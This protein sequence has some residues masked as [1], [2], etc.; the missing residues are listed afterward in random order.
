ME[1]TYASGRLGLRLFHL[2]LLGALLS[3]GCGQRETY[4]VRGTVLYEGKPAVGA[5]VFLH[6][7]GASEPMRSRPSGRVGK[8]GSF[9]IT[10]PNLGDGAKPGD[11]LVT[12]VWRAEAG[13]GDSEEDEDLLPARYL[14]PKTSGLRITVKPGQNDLEPFNLRP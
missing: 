11:Y 13:P 10:T 7:A 1:I 4:P 9:S 5:V 6:P 3:A 12:V 14:D 2:V 8:D